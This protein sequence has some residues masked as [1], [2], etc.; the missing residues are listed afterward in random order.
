M[1]VDW[2][3]ACVCDDSAGLVGGVEEGEGEV[4]MFEEDG[5]VRAP[6]SSPFSEL[7]VWFG[8]TGPEVMSRSVFPA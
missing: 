8:G 7:G 2:G 3:S 5:L 6:S 1:S 4:V